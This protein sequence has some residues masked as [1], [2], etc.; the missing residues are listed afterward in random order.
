MLHQITKFLTILL[1]FLMSSCNYL[2]NEILGTWERQ[3]IIDGGMFKETYTFFESNGE[4]YFTH[5]AEPQGNYYIGSYMEGIWEID[6]DGDLCLIYNLKSIEPIYNPEYVSENEIKEFIKNLKAKMKE[7]NR[8]A[9]AGA[10]FIL[11][12]TD[13]KLSLGA[14]DGAMYFE[15][16]SN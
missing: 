6:M 3:T 14:D 11:D 13:N 7:Q 16:V 9:E 1:L 12:I 10:V 5:I 2:N 15:R 4:N 8:Q